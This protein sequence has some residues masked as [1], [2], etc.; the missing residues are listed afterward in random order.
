MMMFLKN[1]LSKLFKNK[2]QAQPAPVIRQELNNDIDREIEALYAILVDIYGT[3]KLVLLAG[4]MQALTL[5]RSRERAERVLALQ[6]IL[7]EDPM[8]SPAPKEADIPKLLEKL[9]EKAADLIA[10]RKVENS[11]EKKVT[12]KMEKDHQD[13]VND[14]REQVIKEEEPK[15][16]SPQD[17]QK[18]E[19]LERLE[20]IHLTQSVME[21]LRPQS[22]AEVVG[23]QRAVKSLLAKLSSPYPQHLL[24]YGP[25]GV[26]KTTAARLVL[27]AASKKAVSPFAED[28]P[29]IETDGTTLRWD[30]RDMTGAK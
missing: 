1:I 25:P 24:L 22:F 11:I 27:A 21:L 10:R 23:Q 12:E 9:S 3:E 17:K 20:K 6:R 7:A 2:E 15:L 5:L 29:F 8:I 19:K 26:G 13:Y 14:I 16:E 28:A 4:K 18:R 30:P